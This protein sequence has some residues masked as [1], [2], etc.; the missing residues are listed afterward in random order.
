M[1]AWSS[2]DPRATDAWADFIAS[3]GE[4]GAAAAAADAERF[5]ARLHRPGWVHMY[6]PPVLHKAAAEEVAEVGVRLAGL[7]TAFPRRVFGDD[8]GAWAAYLG[9]PAEDAD[10]MAQALRHPRTGR[11]ATAVMR[12]DLVVTDDGL[13]LVELNVSTPMGGLSTLAPYTAATLDSAFGRFLAGRGLTP[14]GPATSRIWLDM[15][16]G[17]VRVPAD[18]PL[19]VFE[20]IAN[21]ADIDSG[22]RFFVD[23]IRSG[24]YEISCGLIADLELTDEGVFF[25]GERIDAVVTMYTWHETKN[26]VPPALTRRLM[27][28]DRALKVDFIGA[29]ATA[30][31]DNKANLA[32]FS[33]PEF[34]ALLTE[35][36]RA[37]V[38]AHVPPTFRLRADT[39]DRA[40]AGREEL[41]CKPASAYG[42]KD[43]AFGFASDDAA[44]RALM[45]ERLADPRERYVLQR[46]LRPAVVVLP[47][48]NPPG[49]EMVLAP[50]VFGGRYAGTFLRQAPPRPESTINASSGAEAAAVLTFAE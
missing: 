9:I 14:G 40:V 33:E 24:G 10:L 48:A 49:R 20:A 2:L 21:P 26:H 23:M 45:A 27:E 29:P 39:L 50:L 44:W 36:E 3:G 46:R 1:S 18:R 7:V 22:R 30:L 28:L 16:A 35:E 12:P 41:I 19:R 31:Y 42:G 25:E 5:Q 47:G 43:M 32:L 15:L 37:L 8:L 34:E 17:L 11:A 38:R 4:A 13:K 6:P